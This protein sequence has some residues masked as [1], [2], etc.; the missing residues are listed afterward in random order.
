MEG[1]RGQTTLSMNGELGNDNLVGSEKRG[2]I[3]SR[4]TI[5]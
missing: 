5:M 3:R 4:K 1:G 2:K